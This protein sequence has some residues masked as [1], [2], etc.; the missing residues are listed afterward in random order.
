MINV[1]KTY[2]PSLK[3]YNKYLKR[4]W[5]TSYVTNDGPLVQEL[6][7]KLKK[8]LGVKHLYLTA[9][10]T[11]GLQMAIKVLKLEG[12]IITTP[13]S[14]V[15]TTSSMVWEQCKPVFVDIDP[16]TL[17]I[18]ANKIEA[19]ITEKTSAILA[20]HVYGNIC[21]LERI[22]KIAKKHNL[23]VIYDAAHAFGVSY[24]G[25][26]VLSYGDISVLSFHATKLF[27][28]V[29]GGALI[30]KNIH[31]A[32]KIRYVRNF[33]HES[34]VHPENIIDIGINAKNSELHAAMGLCMLPKFR[35]IIR[36][37]KILCEKYKMLLSNSHL[38][39]PGTIAGA[40]S[41]YGYFPVIF[42]S[43]KQLL[44]VLT[45]LNKRDI[46][47]RRYFYPSLNTL[48][49]VKYYP[50]PISEDIST[51]ILCL[52]L[53]YDLNIQDVKIISNL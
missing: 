4:I 6:E 9:N 28:T 41:N 12:E 44:S 39:M 23:K 50:C 3:E 22:D 18:D 20:V 2:L 1:T 27:H 29:E 26:S 53:Y 16:R 11:I 24:R 45:F 21:D 43:E 35:K 13:F 47:P 34:S 51:R 8:Y 14:Y 36:K 7:K 32:K 30:T 48:K 49:Y 25:R 5:K 33:G 46:Y 31:I 37:R 10:G 42:N 38:T 19:V 40:T 17:C 15:A 52:P